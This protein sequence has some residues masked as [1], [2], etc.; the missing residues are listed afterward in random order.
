MLSH[1]VL[2][3]DPKTQG[4]NS[5]GTS[6]KLLRGLSLEIIKAALVGTPSREPQEYNR[7]I[8]EDKDPGR[9]IPTI[10]LLYSWGSLFG[11]PNKVPLL[12]GVKKS[13]STNGPRTKEA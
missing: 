6:L 13:I 11:V 3:R 5:R 9:Y 10:I 2:Y 1:R 12:M 4:Y 7:H 8:M